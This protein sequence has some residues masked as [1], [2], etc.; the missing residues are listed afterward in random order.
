M[1]LV[2]ID[3]S[4]INGIPAFWANQSEQKHYAGIVFRVGKIDESVPS[5][6]VSHLVEHLAMFS[7][8]RRDHEMNAIVELL[9]T[10]FFASGSQEQVDRFLQDIC[11]G[12]TS[13]PIDRLEQE[14]QVLLVENARRG[15]WDQGLLS[16]RFGSKGPGLLD[17]PDFGLRR[18]EAEEVQAWTRQ[19]FVAGN[20]AI[21]MSGTP[22][23]LDLALPEGPGRP[24]VT[25]EP[26][27]PLPGWET[28]EMPILALSLIVP[29]AAA[30]SVA[31][32]TIADVAYDEIRM[33]RALAYEVSAGYLP[34]GPNLAQV[35]LA[36][37][38]QKGHVDEIVDATV[39]LVEGLS[40]SGPSP[41]SFARYQSAYEAQR[42]DEKAAA[43]GRIAYEAREILL[44]SPAD[45]VEK[46]DAEFRALTPEAIGEAIADA[47]PSAIY[48]LPDGHVLDSFAPRVKRGNEK[49][50]TG[51]SF[52]APKTE[53]IAGDEGISVV[54][55]EGTGSIARDDCV[56]VL[57]SASGTLVVLAHDGYHF[58]LPLYYFDRPWDLHRATE[59][60]YG[61]ERFTP[62]TDRVPEGRK[63]LELTARDLSEAAVVAP[64]L[65]DLIWRLDTEEALERLLVAR[66]GDRGGLLG[67][68]SS[69]VIFLAVPRD[70]TTEEVFL[71]LRLDEV[72]GATYVP[73]LDQV[74]VKHK[75]SRLTFKKAQ[76][77]RVAKAMVADIRARSR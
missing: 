68:T 71:D 55:H 53:L 16:T 11:A 12:L 73:G 45:P 36:V 56:G 64:E 3:R 61:A 20:A 46:I 47:L 29:R 18:I 21:F 38:A 48:L 2:R 66:S 25:P 70:G 30:S 76:E 24:V 39:S 5:S 63:L 9:Y 65:E 13:L 22:R 35:S 23:E 60:A 49:R 57:E 43:L 6:G 50:F 58:R 74:I 27:V 42:A 10:A 15:S 52:F 17:F 31:S 59:R 40:R 33:K 54:D 8:G 1:N 4:D 77:S 14:R 72:S 19:N 62:V 37:D 7:L 28:H 69:R 26:V 34:L 75:G 67:L 51:A 32:S 41:E 44:G